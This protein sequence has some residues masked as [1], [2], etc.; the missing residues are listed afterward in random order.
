MSAPP[1]EDAIRYEPD[2]PCPPLIALIV[3]AQGVMLALTTMVLVVAI[4]ARAGNQGES[5]LTWA[6]AA[7]LI[8]GGLLTAMQAGRFGRLGAGHILSWGRRPATW[9]SRCWR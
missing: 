7:S 6:V 8:I 3:G 4:T 1:P 5:Y 2:E 9:R